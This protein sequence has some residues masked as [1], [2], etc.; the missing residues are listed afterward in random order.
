MLHCNKM[1]LGWRAPVNR[2]RPNLECDMAEKS[3]QTNPFEQWMDAAMATQAKLFEASADLAKASMK[4]AAELSAE[5]NKAGVDASR[6][7]LE[8]FAR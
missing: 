3:V 5:W 7:A 4:Q 1:G 2:G 8:L 6:K